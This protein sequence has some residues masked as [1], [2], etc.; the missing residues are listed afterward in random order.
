MTWRSTQVNDNISIY[1]QWFGFMSQAKPPQFILKYFVPRRKGE[2]SC[3]SVLEVSIF[4]FFFDLSIEF[5][6]YSDG[7]IF[8]LFFIFT[9]R[10][11][12]CLMPCLCYF[13]LFFLWVV[14]VLVFISR[15]V[16]LFSMGFGCLIVN[17]STS[18]RKKTVYIKISAHSAFLEKP[19]WDT[20]AIEI[21]ESQII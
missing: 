4:F 18:E 6:N 21:L 1:R 9:C 12:V 15:F 14:A 7:V 16:S 8:V 13:D 17:K 11:S 5:W 2:F 19:S 3:I 20:L 10:N